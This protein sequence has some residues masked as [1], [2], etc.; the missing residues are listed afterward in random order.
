MK[1]FAKKSFFSIILFCNFFEL[2]RPINLYSEPLQI[3]TNYLNWVPKSEYILGSGDLL[4]IIILQDDPK[5]NVD[6]VIDQN[7]TSTLKLM[8]LQVFINLLPRICLNIINK[9]VF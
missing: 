1:I 4:N 2:M 3:D 8:R 5:L 6:S 7:G 9:L